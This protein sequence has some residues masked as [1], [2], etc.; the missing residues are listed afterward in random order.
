M[1]RG[2]VRPPI[3]DYFPDTMSRDLAKMLNTFRV[4]TTS[5][6]IEA[7]EDMN[8]LYYKSGYAIK[9]DDKVVT[10]EDRDMC[11]IRPCLESLADQINLLGPCWIRPPYKNLH[12]SQ[13]EVQLDGVPLAATYEYSPMAQ[14][15][16]FRIWL[17]VAPLEDTTLVNTKYFELLRAGFNELKNP[18]P[19]VPGD[20]A[21][22]GQGEPS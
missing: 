10:K 20:Q 7:A 12:S 11:F 21:T 5:E 17:L 3:T 14:A 1:L 22:G 9:D 18:R 6:Q 8:F 19:P 2:N 16:L 4:P 15:D 13:Q